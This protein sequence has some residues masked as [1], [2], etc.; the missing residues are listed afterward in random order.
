MKYWFTVHWPHVG[1]GQQGVWM[2]TSVKEAK[3]LLKKEMKRGD[4]VF[5]YE[6]RRGEDGEKVKGIDGKCKVLA[7]VEVV[8]L[9]FSPG[10]WVEIA[11][12]EWIAPVDCSEE[13][14]H[15]ITEKDSFRRFGLGGLNVL[16]IDRIQAIQILEYCERPSD[17]KKLIRKYFP[18]ELEDAQD[19]LEIEKAPPVDYQKT[20]RKAKFTNAKGGHKVKTEPGIARRRILMAEYKCEIGSD[21]QTFKSRVTNENYVEAH[22]LVPLRAQKQFGENSLDHEANILSLCP[23]CHRLLHHAIID[24]KQNILRKLFKLRKKELKEAGIELTIDQLIDYY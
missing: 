3:Y 19:Q 16:E 2:R 11:E 15:K 14:A 1:N 9:P 13:K 17:Y 4:L 12:T 20:P 24:E 22:H 5:I 10:E 6:T 7:L 18:D 8:R 23:N 21:H